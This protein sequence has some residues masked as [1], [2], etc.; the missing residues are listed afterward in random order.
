MDGPVQV[1]QFNRTADETRT[2]ANIPKLLWT[3]NRHKE[4]VSPI[5]QLSSKGGGGS[6]VV[7]KELESEDKSKTDIYHCLILLYLIV[8]MSLVPV[9]IVYT[10]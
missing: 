6:E 8:Y 3:E 2:T 4:Q 1:E 7:A 5:G 10:Q 9:T